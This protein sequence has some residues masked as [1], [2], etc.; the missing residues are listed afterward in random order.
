MSRRGAAASDL[1]L[2]VE[3]T[4]HLL[5]FGQHDR[6]AA[7]VHL[8]GRLADQADRSVVRDGFL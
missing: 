5:A 3:N 8:I 6:A 4:H 1:K 7:C 2:G